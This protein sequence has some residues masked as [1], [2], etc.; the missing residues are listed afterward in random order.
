MKKT[1]V[2]NAPYPFNR[3]MVWDTSEKYYRDAAYVN[4]F[5]ILD[6][7]LHAFMEAPDTVVCALI[8]LARAGNAEACEALL[9]YQR[10]KLDIFQE[11]EVTS[12]FGPRLAEAPVKPST[13]IELPTRTSQC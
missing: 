4:L 11:I 3:T 5:K 8:E 10:N 2:F 12:P 7:E 6:E 9:C 13:V 1:L